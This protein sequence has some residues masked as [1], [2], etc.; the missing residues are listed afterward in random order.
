M[1][2][3]ARPSTSSCRSPT[4]AERPP[5]SMTGARLPRPRP[6]SVLT[7]VGQQRSRGADAAVRL[8]VAA[9]ITT[10]VYRAN[11]RARAGEWPRR[12]R[13]GSGSISVH[14]GGLGP[15]RLR[16]RFSSKDPEAREQHALRN[17][18]AR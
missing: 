17:L 9:T 16:G 3:D 4:P 6:S 13:F 14:L 1:R 18:V 7:N 11:H 12:P 8:L 15:P 10:H 2:E 5:V